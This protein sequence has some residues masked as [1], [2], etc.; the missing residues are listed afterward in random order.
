MLADSSKQDET[1]NT[2]I[3]YVTNEWHSDKDLA[4][5]EKYYYAKKSGALERKRLSILGAKGHY[6]VEYATSY[7]ERV[8][9]TSVLLKSRCLLARMF[10]DQ[11]LTMRSER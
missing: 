5:N 3:R 8:T 1:I 6:A 7:I 4:E 11:K 2:V 9:C 10:G